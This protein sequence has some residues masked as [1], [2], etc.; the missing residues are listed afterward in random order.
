MFEQLQAAG[1]DI[2]FTSHAEGILEMD[3]HDAAEQIE[4]VLKPLKINVS[5]LIAS[6]GGQ[7]QITQRLKSA[8]ETAGWTKR[9]FEV[10]E[11]VKFEMQG[12]VKEQRRESQTHEVDH[13][14]DFPNGCLLLEIEWN[15]KDPFYDRD[16]DNFR[17][18]HA[19]GAAS[20]GIVVTRGASLQSALLHSISDFFGRHNVTAGTDLTSFKAKARTERQDSEVTKMVKRGVPFNVALARKFVADKFGQASTHWA[21]LQ[22]RIQRGLGNPCPLLMIGIPESVLVHD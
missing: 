17:R 10:S 9:N 7:A 15:N 19:V 20:V 16:L 21:K 12:A 13:V 8:F 3:F 11:L 1:Y 18:L 4:S 2:A 22:E 6:G 5:D 14:K